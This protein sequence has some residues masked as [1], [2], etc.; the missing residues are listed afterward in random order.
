MLIAGVPEVPD[1]G[2]EKGYLIGVI[3][4]RD[5][6]LQRDIARFAMMTTYEETGRVFEELTPAEQ[7]QCTENVVL[8]S[9][10]DA[11]DFTFFGVFCGGAMVGLGILSALGTSKVMSTL[12]G[13]A[14]DKAHERKGVGSSLVRYAEELAGLLD[15]EWIILSSGNGTIGFYEKLGYELGNDLYTDIKNPMFKNIKP[16]K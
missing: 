4:P 12:R 9:E 8:L 5:D 15:R 2:L 13:I 16:V 3:D 6:V 14:V 1:Y 10:A 11:E 7:Q